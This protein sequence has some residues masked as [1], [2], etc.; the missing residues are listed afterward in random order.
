MEESPFDCWRSDTIL[1]FEASSSVACKQPPIQWLPQGT[2]PG[3]KRPGPE[4]CHSAP[5]S[6]E[7]KNGWISTSTSTYAFILHTASTLPHTLTNPKKARVIGQT[8][9]KFIRLLQRSDP[10]PSNLY[11]LQAVGIPAL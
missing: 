8:S 6:A 1:F 2:F 3:V 7:I 5:P 11:V 10:K 4:T 9:C